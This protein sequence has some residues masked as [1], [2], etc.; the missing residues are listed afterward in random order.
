MHDSRSASSSPRRV[1]L[2][3]DSLIR[4]GYVYMHSF[5]DKQ[6]VIVAAVS[7]TLIKEAMHKEYYV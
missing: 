5:F 3:L 2:S 7:R 1:I 6:D 4:V